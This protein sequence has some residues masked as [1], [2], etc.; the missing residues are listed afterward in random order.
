MKSAAWVTLLLGIWLLVSPMVLH[1]TGTLA[2]NNLASGIL[3]VLASIWALMVAAPRH[4]AG[5]VTLL[6]AFWV[7]SAPYALNV[8]TVAD[9][10][11]LAN[12][13]LC[14]SLLAIFAVVRTLSPHLPSRSV[15]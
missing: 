2:T 13:G 7:F 6:L 8:A 12:N 11:T 14:G 10:P 9:A 15:A 1:N 4:T 5:W 3:V